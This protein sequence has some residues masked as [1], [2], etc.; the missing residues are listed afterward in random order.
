MKKFGLVIILLVALSLVLAACGDSPTAVTT[1]SSATTTAATV[2]SNTTST[3]VVANST[4]TKAA[5]TQAPA[6]TTATNPTIASA[7]TST[8]NGTPIP[9]PTVAVSAEAQQTMDRIGQEASKVRGL[10]F[11]D[12]IGTNFMTRDD[13]GKYNLATFKRD[14]PPEEITKYEK[15]FEAFG[16]TKPGFNLLDTYVKLY[17]EQVLGFYDP[18]TKKLYVVTEDPSKGA[19]PLVKFTAEHELTHALQDQNYDLNKLRPIRK[20]TDK[21]GNDDRDLAI[22]AL[23]EGD[24]VQSQNLWLTGRYL[25]SSDL[26]DLIKETQNYSSDSLNQ[27]PLILRDSLEFPYNEGLSFVTNLYKQGGWAGVNKAWTDYPPAS[28]SQ[29]LHFDKYQK[30]V[31]PVKVDLSDLTGL[32]GDGWKSLDINTMGEFQ[33]RIWLKGQLTADQASKGAAGWAGD[34]YQVLDKDGKAGFVWRSSWDSET[35]AKEFF[36]FANQYVVPTYNLQGNGGS[37]DK[38]V[39]QTADKDVQLIRKGQE[40]LVLAMPKGDAAAKI[41]GKLGF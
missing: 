14:N 22:T 3:P 4:P 33:T 1:T 35:E 29:I 13:L 23:I 27:A 9:V 15:I 7:T 16:F 38:R 10:N 20:P 24:A 2:S 12:K 30:K 5:A 28:T 41:V 18:D 32:L 36:D 26:N 6:G 17:T 39:W 8:A 37:G 34:R 40:V 19:S 11:K 31:E 25:S 21:E